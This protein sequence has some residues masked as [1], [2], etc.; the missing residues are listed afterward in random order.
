VHQDLPSLHLDDR[1]RLRS[2][3]RLR[4]LLLNQVRSASMRA[5]PSVLR[6]DLEAASTAGVQEGDNAAGSTRM[7][8]SEDESEGK[9]GA[10]DKRK[11][12][13]ARRKKKAGELKR[14]ALLPA[15]WDS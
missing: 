9:R 6:H 1:V 7:V 2:Q 11:Q 3:A 12:K 10:K 13:L 5:V 14:A 15:V 4:A 8:E